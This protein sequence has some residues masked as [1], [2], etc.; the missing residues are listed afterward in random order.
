MVTV[1]NDAVVQGLSQKCACEIFGIAPRK[2]RRWTNPKP[3]RPRTAWNKVL[4]HERD[5]IE[6][7]AWMPELIGKP[8][9]H[10]FVHGHESGMFFASLSTVYRVLK[11]KNMVEPRKHWH[12]TTPYVSA[13]SLLD[14]GF[15]LLCYDGT[16]FSTD[17]GIIVWAIPVMILPQR[18]L[19]HIGHSI[20]GISSGDLTQSVK[21]AYALLPE[22][23]TTKM[24]AHSDRGSA[25]K[26]SS[27]KQVIKE[28]LGAPVHFGRPHTPDDQ[29]W[30]EAFI[31]TLKYHR[32]APRSFKL[33]DDIL[34]WLN[35][36]PDIYNN[37]PHS[38]LS[39][40]T[41]LQALS[42]QKEVILN[43]RKQN[44]ATACMLR[45]TAWKASRS[46]LLPAASE[47]VMQSA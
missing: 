22:R 32:D 15:S 17:S 6:A 5:T 33:V 9:S 39:Y 16:Q 4:E 10:I 40:V 8:V 19:L 42:G 43:Q 14:E 28:L 35:R 11:D 13:H 18:Y 31:K 3:I 45:Y 41:P 46:L 38:S 47:V 1:I 24:L 20:N 27:T 30:I 37:D 7:A 36:V 25:M 44:L 21:E 29:A 23:L 34:Q 12:R 26:A 2:F